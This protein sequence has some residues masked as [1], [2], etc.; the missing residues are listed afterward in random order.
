AALI[1]QIPSGSAINSTLQGDSTSLSAL[2]NTG[3]YAFNI[4]NNR[5]RNNVTGHGDYVMSPKNNLSLTFAYNTDLLDRPD[6]ATNFA[7]VPNVSND[8]KVKLL[9]AVWRIVPKPNMTNEVRFGFNL[10][11]ALFLT[12]EK[13]GDYLFAVSTSASSATGGLLF[14]NPVNTFRAQGRFTNTY[15]FADHGSYTRGKHNIQFGY[16]LQRAFTEPYND[17]GITPTY[18]V[19]ISSLNTNGLGTAQLP[20]ASSTDIST[21]N[22]LLA[23]LVGYLSSYTQTFNVTSRTSGFVNGATSDRHWVVDDH[24]AYIQDNWKVQRRLTLNLGLR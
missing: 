5:I 16:Q 18:T 10:A 22:N 7:L 15:N 14:S 4:R 11:P 13:F 3:G 23:N 21:A 20:G 9:S 2:K 24:S 8:D 12:N 6:L 1:K 19:G 17:A